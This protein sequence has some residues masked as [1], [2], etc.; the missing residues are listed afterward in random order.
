MMSNQ[1][2]AKTV[3]EWN[4]FHLY[5]ISSSLI[6]LFLKLKDKTFVGHQNTLI[7]Y[8]CKCISSISSIDVKK[9]HEVLEAPKKDEKD[10]LKQDIF[11]PISKEEESVLFNLN[12]ALLS[13]HPFYISAHSLIKK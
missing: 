7:S 12:S 10:N 6:P 1:D 9:L 3:E 4:S 11:Y 8:F 5:H 2:D 13:K